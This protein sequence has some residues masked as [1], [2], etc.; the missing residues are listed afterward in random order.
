MERSSSRSKA[1]RRSRGRPTAQTT[2]QQGAGTAEVARVLVV[3]NS[4]VSLPSLTVALEDLGLA[5]REAS[6][7]VEAVTMARSWEPDIV[8]LDTQLQDASGREVATWLRSHPAMRTT[9]IVL[10][11]DQARATADLHA[12][13]DFVFLDRT[14]STP[15]F[16]MSIRQVLRHRHAIGDAR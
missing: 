8:L 11:G 14:S 2:T 15:D 10:L 9:P 12:N 7:G 5:V 3:R 16:R 13:T 4:A 6:R 1:G